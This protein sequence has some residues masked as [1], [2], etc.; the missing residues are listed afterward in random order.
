VYDPV[1]KL[2]FA[3]EPNLGIVDAISVANQQIVAKIPVPG[4]YS[5]SI[6]PNGAE[7]LASTNM[8]QV[9]WIDTTLLR[10]VRWQ[11]LPKVNDPIQGQQYFAPYVG[12]VS[13]NGKVLFEALEGGFTSTLVQW[14]PAGNTAALRSDGPRGGTMA[15]SANGAKVFFA[16]GPSLYDSATDKFLTSSAF[17]YIG[18]AAANPAGTQF[19]LFT[20]SGITFIDTQFNVLGQLPLNL[21]QAPSPTGLIYSADGRFLY[22]VIPG[23]TPVLIT[24]DTSRYQIAG[25]APAYYD[26]LNAETPL[27][28]DETG[29]VFGSAGGGL[30][31]D[32]STNFQA[33]TAS[34][35][36]PWNGFIS[37]S[38][39]PIQGGTATTLTTGLPG[40]LPDVWFGSQLAAGEN[41]GASGVQATTPPGKST[42]PVNIKIVEPNGTMDVIPMGFTY[43]STL[44]NPAPLAA[45]PS[46]GTYADI[47]GFGLGADKG[48]SPQVTIGG[49]NA[50]IA[51]SRQAGGIPRQ[52]LTVSVPPG[53]P[54]AADIMVKSSNGS[55]SIS[56][57]F[58]YLNSVT[59]YPTNDVL[60]SILYD[61][62]R[63]QLY[64]NAG[65][66]IDVFSLTQRS[67]SASITPP[68]FR[69]IHQLTGMALT[70]DDTKLLVANFD[71]NSL[72]IIDPDNPSAARAVQVSPI[73]PVY[74][75]PAPVGLATTNKN[76]V[77]GFGCPANAC[78]TLYELDL[79]TLQFKW[80]QSGGNYLLG[81][82]DG[83]QAYIAGFNSSG[84]AVL[85]WSA[86]T[87]VW[88]F[89]VIGGAN[90]LFYND[91][92]VA[93][94]GNVFA[95]NND[96]TTSDFPY[97]MMVDSQLNQISQLG[98][99]SIFSAA[100]EMGVALHDTGSLLYSS[101]N[102]GVDI[103]DVKHGALAER[104][105]LNE[106]DAFRD[107]SLAVDETGQT[108]FLL[109]NAELTIIDLDRVPVSIGSI[110]PGA[111][112]AGTL[113]KI[114]G[115]GFQA[116]LSVTF[117][118]TIAAATLIDPDTIQVSVPPITPGA[119]QV[120]IS[121]P[122]GSSY[123]LDSVFAVQ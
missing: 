40:V 3:G 66:H 98:I 26:P 32:D 114:R 69:G 104:I 18:L 35:G 90:F 89:H 39:G 34:V 85:G 24:V 107:G 4:V 103:I 61:Q 115:S 102:Y 17:G 117:N 56:K 84:G 108:I 14:D 47:V 10:V 83:A 52:I 6:T 48:G 53:V 23:Q 81:S 95:V 9:A 19:A 67:F 75:P 16:A 42:G 62:Q 87:D 60:Q 116:G 33:L 101:T 22:I 106:Q 28:A 46:G 71:D 59:D 93:G 43:G 122:D 74:N 27:A 38:E 97:P 29:F 92:A 13:A 15:S 100:N 70:P 72:A 63:Q 21:V 88:Q 113:I 50:N 36:A 118:G 37:P 99:E 119:A 45:A 68:N 55:A 49:N 112:T 44:L 58:H 73:V 5:L 12:T 20:G 110:T 109:T 25:T 96:F 2:V 65:N 7:V 1:H 79:G 105:L 120:V 54:G 64:L 51:A 41:L 94:D 11:I 121:N 76:T 78:G 91:A 86:A 80:L 77:F 82:K 57:G 111:G 8:Q 31:F 123:S 30:V